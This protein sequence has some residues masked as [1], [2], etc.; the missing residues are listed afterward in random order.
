MRGKEFAM[1][2]NNNKNNARTTPFSCLSEA[3][4]Q[5]VREKQL[6]KKANK[7]RARAEAAAALEEQ[8]EGACI[9]CLETTEDRFVPSC[10]KRTKIPHRLCRPCARDW[11][12]HAVATCG[13]GKVRCPCAGCT[14]QW[15]TRDLSDLGV[16]KR[17]EAA[18]SQ[19]PVY[20]AVT[21]DGG[22][23][24]C[25]ECRIV[26]LCHGCGV[27]TVRNGGCPMLQCTQC[28]T[29]WQ[30][31]TPSLITSWYY[32]RRGM[33]KA[34]LQELGAWLFW[35]TH[36]LRWVVGMS[37][38]ASVGPLLLWW[39]FAGVIGPMMGVLSCV[40]VAF[41]LLWCTA[42]VSLWKNTKYF[43]LTKKLELG[44]SQMH[45]IDKL[46]V[47]SQLDMSTTGGDAGVGGKSPIM[48]I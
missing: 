2:N 24:E 11:A 19:S 18:Q 45:K 47:D 1:R 39:A 25:I 21:H 23:D 22:L 4:K 29:A 6:R 14:A 7:E 43:H 30:W 36:I 37:A 8:N 33:P 12:T 16:A 17:G 26:Q 20:S 38:V 10:G 34:S 9:V 15:D 13:S 31:G 3:E 5:I 28:E 44:T 27:P 48:V 32:A 40:D 42:L 46:T 35:N 41:V